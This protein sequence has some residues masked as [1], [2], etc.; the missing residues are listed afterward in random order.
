MMKK[1]KWIA[2]TSLTALGIGVA[3]AFGVPGSASLNDPLVRQSGK[4]L[5]QPFML[6]LYI[7]TDFE[8]LVKNNV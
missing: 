6:T 8:R 4:H 1:P 5:N 3:L 2:V 7:S